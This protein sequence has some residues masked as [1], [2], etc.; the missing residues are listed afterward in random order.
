VLGRHVEG[1]HFF[2]LLLSNEPALTPQQSFYQR[3][4]SGDAAEATYQSELCLKDQSLETYLDRVALG[5]LKLAER[6]DRRGLLDDEHEAKIVH[7]V[8]EM[9]ENLSDFEPRRWFFKL[10]LPS[11]KNGK[12]ENGA[13]GHASLAEDGEANQ[14]LPVVTR[15]ELAAGWAVDEPILCI[16]G[17]SGLDEA[18]AALLAAVL[19]KRGLGARA[20][21]PETL[22]AGHIASLSGTEAKLVCLSYLG[23]GT[24]AAHIRYLVRR[25]RRILP[26]GTCILLGYWHGESDAEQVK[27]LL[28]T[29]AAD[30]YASSLG[31]AV[32]FCVSAA[33]GRI[34]CEETGHKKTAAAPAPKAKRREP[35]RKPQTA[36]A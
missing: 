26:E 6:E 13:A 15:G 35:K 3:A 33:T 25:L 9:L 31:E 21:S 20:L 32:E 8:K 5:G 16:G 4:L 2:E 11:E 27:A 18:A 17:R 14:D 23:L 29:A 10:R 19:E 22:S 12:D 36:S 34:A 1:L 30:A 28:A 24:G 7:T